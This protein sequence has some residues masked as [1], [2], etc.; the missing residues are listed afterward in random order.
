MVPADDTPLMVAASTD[1]PTIIVGSTATLSAAATGGTTPYLFRWDQNDGPANVALAEVTAEVLTTP[2]LVISGRYVFR[3]SVT[4]GAGRRETAFVTVQVSPAMT[5]DARVDTAE[6]FEGTP[7][8][9]S[10]MVDGVNAP[11][12]FA[13]EMADGPVALDVSGEP[14]ASL[15]T[16]PLTV[17]GTYTFRVTAR[18]SAGFEESDTA[19][20]TVASAVSVSMPPLAVFGEPAPL[21]A[22]VDTPAEGVTLL[23]EVLTGSA[24]FDD[25][26]SATPLITVTAGDTLDVRLTLSVPVTDGSPAEVVRELAIVAVADLRP[27]VRVTTNF[28]DMVIELDGDAAPGHTANLLRYVDERFFD[29]L[30]FHRNAC[31]PDQVTRECVAPF[32]L[33]GGGYLRVNGELELKDPTH[34]P[35]VSESPNGLSNGTVY[36]VSLALSGSDRDSGTTQLFINLADNSFL[37]AQGFT[38]FGLVVEGRDV[39]DAIVAME[40]TDSPIIPGEV[41]LPVED[42]IMEDVRRVE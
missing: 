1:T 14:E 23:W 38:V 26:T 4:D 33:Q 42:V 30:L 35:V 36:S 27:R 17:A 22:T 21:M 11:F 12:T 39:V 16:V 41:S 3:I 15:T 2:P 32:V 34:D 10:A 6:V 7:V 24:V 18:D 29:G 25:A 9:I 19:E 28:G 13:W 5:I 8:T 20:I 40:T 31:T 37:D